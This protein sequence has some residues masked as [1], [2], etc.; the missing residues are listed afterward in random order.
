MTS[1]SNSITGGNNI[2]VTN[3]DGTISV[4]VSS[5]T[6]HLGDVDNSAADAAGEVLIWNNSILSLF[7]T[8]LQ[9]VRYL[10]N[11]R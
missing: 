7:Q 9:R 4:L 11:K 3:G 5:N 8:H 2:T 6:T 1:C 10:Y